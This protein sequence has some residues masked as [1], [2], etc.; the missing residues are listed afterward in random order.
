MAIDEVIEQINMLNKKG[1]AL[2]DKGKYDTAFEEH[3]QALHLTEENKGK[4]NPDYNAV[5]RANLG[6][7]IRWSAN[8]REEALDYMLEEAQEG[9]SLKQRVDRTLGKIESDSKE[10]NMPETYCGRARLLEEIGLVIRYNDQGTEDLKQGLGYIEDSISFYEKALENKDNE[11]THHFGIKDRFYRT[12]GIAATLALKL[13]DRAKALQYAQKEVDERKKN[14]ETKGFGLMNAYHTLGVVQTEWVRTDKTVYAAAKENLQRAGVLAGEL[15]GHKVVP[16]VLEFR[17][18][19]LDYV[20]NPEENARNIRGHM[21]S[22]LGAQ[23]DDET[24]WP[25]NIRAAL[26]DQ[27]FELGKFAGPGYLAK[28]EQMYAE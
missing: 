4:V 21:R 23:D 17:F 25:L 2:A 11:A 20:T 13:G 10:V 3:M 1:V 19:W 26:K 18:A 15:E 28:I 8:D 9:E 14:G 12:T 6:Y 16:S 5:T 7:A 27:M 22:V 24:A